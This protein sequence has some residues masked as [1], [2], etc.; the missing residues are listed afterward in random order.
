[1]HRESFARWQSTTIQQ[2][3]YSINLVLALSTASLG[4]AFALARDGDF[5]GHCWAKT[6]SSM[7]LLLFT[8]SVSLGIAVTLNRLC[9]FRKTTQIALD[10]ESWLTD[11]VS[12]IDSK[13]SERRRQV[14]RL[15]DWTWRLFYGQVVTFGA[16]II[17]LI[18]GLGIAHR[19]KLF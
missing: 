7:S 8:L 1:M 17:L 12:D 3:G 5:Q 9:D 18:T 13:L 10:R 2:L 4:F 11:G 16:A 14:R 6:L 19:S 15:G